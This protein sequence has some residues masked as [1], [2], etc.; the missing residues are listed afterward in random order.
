M[1]FISHRGNLNGKNPDEENSISYIDKAYKNC[2]HVEIDVRFKK[3]KWY[4]GHDSKYT[5]EVDFDYIKRDGF[6]LHCKNIEA[7]LELQGSKLNYFWHQ[8]DAYTLTSHNFIWCYP[9]KAV[10]SKGFETI[11]VLPEVNNTNIVNF[12]GVCTDHIVKYK[13]MANFGITKDRNL[14]S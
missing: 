7:L 10:P 14:S 11:A 9:G 6:W 8:K 2:A 12:S 5:T 1:K 3:N 4:L 13:N